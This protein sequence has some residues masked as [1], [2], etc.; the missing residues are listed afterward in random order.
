M[1]NILNE[2]RKLINLCVKFFGVDRFVTR[3]LIKNTLMEK[4]CLEMIEKYNISIGYSERT[5]TVIKPCL[6]KK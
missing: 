1:V 5:N 2:D 3:K 4:D 6:S